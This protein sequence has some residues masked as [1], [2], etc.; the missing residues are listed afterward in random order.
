MSLY[1]LPAELIVMIALVH[2]MVWARLYKTCKHFWIILQ[3]HRVRKDAI[4]AFD[5]MVRLNDGV[6]YNQYSHKGYDDPVSKCRSAETVKFSPAFANVPCVYASSLTGDRVL[7]DIEGRT[8]TGGGNEHIK[9]NSTLSAYLG[10]GLLLVYYARAPGRNCSC[11][12]ADIVDISVYGYRRMRSNLEV[13]HN[14]CGSS[15]ATRYSHDSIILRNDDGIYYIDGTKYTTLGSER[16]VHI[17]GKTAVHTHGV[18]PIWGLWSCNDDNVQIRHC[19]LFTSVNSNTWFKGHCILPDG[20]T[21][22]GNYGE[23]GQFAALDARASEPFTKLAKHIDPHLAST[24]NHV[25]NGHN[26]V[27]FTGHHNNHKC[28][29]LDFDIR[30]NKI[31][32]RPHT[33]K[34]IR[35]MD[36]VPINLGLW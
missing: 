33:P 23:W 11:G 2:P 12:P 15:T 25:N 9:I 7:Y 14:R 22:I 20:T 17:V 24:N 10:D 13:L 18:R 19:G 4:R 1:T 27:T 26:C 28:G 21:I 8:I 5:R 34:M 6:L 3:D 31:T 36:A 16:N 35:D 32:R 29:L 30:A